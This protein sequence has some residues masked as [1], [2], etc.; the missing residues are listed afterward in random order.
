MFVQHW[1]KLEGNQGDPWPV[2]R[3]Y[4]AAVCLGHGRDYPQ[5]LITGGLDADLDT[6]ND[7]WTLDIESMRWRE[8]RVCEC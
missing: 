8:V 5:L 4:H 2:G 3:Q 7:A 1:S 6:L